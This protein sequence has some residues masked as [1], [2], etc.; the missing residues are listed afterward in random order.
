MKVD[1]GRRGVPP[2]AVSTNS[3][4]L[5]ATR[6]VRSV[7]VDDP[8]NGLTGDSI[9]RTRG[10]AHDALVDARRHADR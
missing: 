2:T 10:C 3:P 5:G 4:Q 1:G 9:A 8:V 6:F 7:P